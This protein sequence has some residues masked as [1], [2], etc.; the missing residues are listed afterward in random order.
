MNTNTVRGL[1]IS[2]FTIDGLVPFLAAESESP[3]FKCEVAPFD[4]VMQLLLDEKADCWRLKPEVAVVWT[5][6]QAA[7]KSF[8]R[9]LS[10]EPV[11]TDEILTEVD[12]FGACLRDAARRVST[13]FV[14]T[15]TWPAHDRGLGLL[16]MSTHVG[17]A[18]HLMRMNVRLAE[19]VAGAV[20]I[21]LVDAGRW[22]AL[23][24]AGANNPK[25][26]HL[27]KIAFGPEVFKQAAADIKAGV[28]AIKGQ[29]R[30]L[31]VLDLDDTLWGGICG[32]VGWENLNLGGHDPLGEAFCA[33]Q[34]ALKALANRG[35]VLAI[36]SKNTEAVALEA[37]DRHPEM[38]LRR[39]DFVGWRINWDDKAQNLVDLVAELNLGLEAVVFIDDSPVERARI[40]EALPA[41]HVPEWP[42]DKLLYEK[43]LVEL[44]CFDTVAISEED[45]A[46]TR[47]Y[48]SERSRQAA[49]ASVQSLEEYL[50]SLGLKLIVERLGPAT[51]QRATQLL[52]KTNQLN[53]TTRRMTETQLMEWAG[54][55]DHQVYV[56]RVADRFDDYGLTGV[57]SLAVNGDAA[58]VADFV[59]SCR[60]IGRGVEQG[61]LHVLME[62]AREVSLKQL[63]ADYAPTPLNAPCKLF[64]DEH[65]NLTRL[66]DSNRYVWDLLQPY[67]PPDH[68]TI[69]HVGET[70]CT[71][72][73]ASDG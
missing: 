25:L 63:V 5:R 51:L 59:M 29:S 73:L 34:R 27:G 12:R 1:L 39:S 4:Q 57:A 2:D 22:M 70:I 56:F 24:G 14:P 7:I 55:D 58:Y 41:V 38:V 28:R 9:L 65:S 43:A 19:A 23:T 33:F 44:N 67:P 32:D 26:W 71:S 46:R 35:I 66:S 53:L 54:A 60:V 3:S 21:H 11:P 31:V 36:V 62:H 17:P 61:I 45:R 68:L 47:M 49:R 30:K 13:L 52:N 48:V 20:N 50:R 6:P 18:Y 40:R 15:W 10:V 64:F 72:A 16:N 37:M 69:Q 8:A 42:A